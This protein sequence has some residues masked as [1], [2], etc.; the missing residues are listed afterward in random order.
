MYKSISNYLNS[1]GM[2]AALTT[3][4][5]GSGTAPVDIKPLEFQYVTTEVVLLRL[6]LELL[7]CYT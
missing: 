4:T 5:D 6:L 1:T 7:F 3:A 2:I